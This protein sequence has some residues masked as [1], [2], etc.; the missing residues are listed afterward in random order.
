MIF[1][2]SM[3]DLF[4]QDVPFEFIDKVMDTIMAT[5]W[6][7]YQILTKRPYN[8][9]EYSKYSH[10]RHGIKL[11]DIKNLWLGVSVEDQETADERIPLLLQVPASTRFLSMEPLLGSVTLKQLHYEDIVMINCLSGN[12]GMTFPLKGLNNKIDWVIVGGE[13]G[14]KARPMHPDWVKSI[15][16]ECEADNTPFFFKQWGEWREGSSYNHKRNIQHEIVLNDG[17]RFSND[18]NKGPLSIPIS[19]WQD[20]NPTVMSKVGK[21]KAGNLLDGKEYKAFPEGK[22]VLDEQ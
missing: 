18:N 21:S 1:V 19:E 6:H 12:H 10:Q 9:V 17:R 14:H 22:E 5:P 13:S 20:G 3:S 15:R 4:H 2:N 7:C 11:S 16:D 8:L